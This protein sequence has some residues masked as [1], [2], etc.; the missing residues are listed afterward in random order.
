MGDIAGWDDEHRALVRRGLNIAREWRTADRTARV[1]EPDVDAPLAGLATTPR[2][3]GSVLA[4]F[5]VGPDD[6]GRAVRWRCG[7]G[8]LCD[9]WTGERRVVTADEVTAG[10]LLDTSVPTG[11]ALSIHPV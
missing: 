9:E 11:L 5:V 10:V 6:V 8:T 7:P 1:V 4:T 2:P 3:D